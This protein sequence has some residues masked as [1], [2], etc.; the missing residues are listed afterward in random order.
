MR[1]TLPFLSFP[2][3]RFGSSAAAYTAH[4][5]QYFYLLPLLVF[6]LFLFVQIYKYICVLFLDE[7]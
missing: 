1:G 5:F 6:S 4:V 3:P 2:S 7:F